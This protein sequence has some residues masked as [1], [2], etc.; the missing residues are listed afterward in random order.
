MLV[1]PNHIQQIVTCFRSAE[2]QFENL[3]ESILEILSRSVRMN[4]VYMISEANFQTLPNIVGPGTLEPIC[5]G[6]SI[7]LKLPE[8]IR[9]EKPSKDVENNI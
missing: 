6:N 2:Q 9:A 3:L 7:P 1:A 4:Q 5:D 8:A